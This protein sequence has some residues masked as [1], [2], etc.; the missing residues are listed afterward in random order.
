MPVSRTRASFLRGACA[1]RCVAAIIAALSTAAPMSLSA[2]TVRGI[3]RVDGSVH[4]SIQTSILLVD[5]TG[6]P[7][8]GMM[9]DEDGGYA[10]R[11]PRPGS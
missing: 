10:L 4:A 5:E 8:A 6:S 1:A 7:V 2:Q 11:A 9:T 3:A